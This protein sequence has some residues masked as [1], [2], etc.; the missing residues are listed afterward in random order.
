MN[1]C[2]KG[3]TSK[4][5]CGYPPTKP[6]SWSANVYAEGMNVVRVGDGWV[7]HCKTDCHAPVQSGGSSSVF[8]NGKAIARVDDSMSCGDSVAS[9]AATVFSG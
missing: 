6:D 5:A 2:F 9:G 1:V 7:A 3:S 4:G 8:V